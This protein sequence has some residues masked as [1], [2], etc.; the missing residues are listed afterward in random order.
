M[1]EPDP[2]AHSGGLSRT[3][4]AIAI[5]LT[6]CL[7]LAYAYQSSQKTELASALN[8]SQATINT[9]TAKEKKLLADLSEAQNQLS[10]SHEQTNRLKNDIS[11]LNGRLKATEDQANVKES[12]LQAALS[13]YQAKLDAATTRAKTINKD[14]DSRKVSDGQTPAAE[15]ANGMALSG[16]EQKATK[17]RELL[18]KFTLVT[19][20]FT[21]PK[22]YLHSRFANQIT[23]ASKD[24][25][26]DA[27]A[28]LTRLTVDTEGR[29]QG[30]NFKWL[31]VLHNDE[32]L[33]FEDIA[34][35]HRFLQSNEPGE[36]PLKCR[37]AWEELDLSGP[38][39]PVFRNVKIQ[40]RPTIDK[41]YDLLVSKDEVMAI[42][43]TFELAASFKQ[44]K[45][46]K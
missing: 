31:K 34:S 2:N 38:I 22:A 1:K 24:T 25:A 33:N 45:E 43:E 37:M 29:V 11:A 30:G 16:R 36:A 10:A 46:Q 19:D 17:N 18:M 4:A 32:V 3:V 9:L 28:R 14:N 26:S 40:T 41:T 7:G 13:S 20:E 35:F 23:A 21:R 6:A 12:E 39:S 5:L 8:A 42:K 15:T 44:A 27:H